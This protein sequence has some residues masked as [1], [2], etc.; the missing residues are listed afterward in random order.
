[1]SAEKRDRPIELTIRIGRKRVT[2]RVEDERPSGVRVREIEGAILQAATRTPATTKA[3]AKR[4]GY[5]LNSY[6]RAAVAKLVKGGRLVR[7][8]GGLALP[9][10]KPD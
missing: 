3:L 5:R 8:S 6:F 10:D 1:M 9:P 2:V 7:V 4:S